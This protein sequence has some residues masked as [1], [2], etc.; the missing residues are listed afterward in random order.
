MEKIMQNACGKEYSSDPSM[1]PHT[2]PSGVTDIESP[3][4][5]NTTSHAENL[6]G[7]NLEAEFDRVV[8]NNPL[9]FEIENERP[10]AM[11]RHGTLLQRENDPFYVSSRIVRNMKL[12]LMS[13]LPTPDKT[14]EETS[15]ITPQGLF[16]LSRETHQFHCI[17]NPE[18]LNSLGFD[19]WLNQAAQISETQSISLYPYL[20][21]TQLNQLERLVR[22]HRGFTITGYNCIEE[23]WLRLTGLMI[24]QKDFP[25]LPNSWS[26]KFLDVVQM[27]IVGDLVSVSRIIAHTSIIFGFINEAYF[28]DTED[29]EANAWLFTQ[30]NNPWLLLGFTCLGMMSLLFLRGNFI[31]RDK[32]LKITQ[33]FT[34]LL[35]TTIGYAENWTNYSSLILPQSI[36]LY[37]LFP[38]VVAGF[39]RGFYRH[40]KTSPHKIDITQYTH[41]KFLWNSSCYALTEGSLWSLGALYP[42]NTFCFLFKPT[43]PSTVK[44]FN[45]DLAAVKYSVCLLAFI[46]HFLRHPHL[47]VSQ[48]VVGRYASNIMLAIG[49]SLL[50]N[51]ALCTL[52]G[53]LYDCLFN[54]NPS[55]KDT[56]QLTGYY[57]FQILFA[58]LT[59]LFSFPRT[60]ELPEYHIS[61]ESQNA[62][63]KQATQKPASYFCLK[64]PFWQRNSADKLPHIV[65]NNPTIPTSVIQVSP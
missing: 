40:E 47:S 9:H 24:C 43:T 62:N 37:T 54:Q 65:I 7:T 22:A 42:I 18:Q 52:L 12:C 15:I 33:R 45:E 11:E 44:A 41:L 49:E 14:W 38:M 32:A 16:Q 56:G 17:L 50:D 59:F 31:A 20:T 29:N 6:T 64:T 1:P 39:L 48:Q 28:E 13:S 30:H 36:V 21:L 27:Q 35:A 46:A 23:F 61:T 26:R 5:H 34:L 53:A 4:I 19:I 55:P 2:S 58:V 60:S 3:P 10:T 51:A 63:A 8:I 57:G 25:P